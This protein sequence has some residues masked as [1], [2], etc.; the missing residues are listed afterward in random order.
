MTRLS[1]IAKSSEN[2]VVADSI[3]FTSITKGLDSVMYRLDITSNLCIPELGY[4]MAERVL[5]L[6]FLDTMQ[7]NIE[8]VNMRRS[9][10]LV[11]RVQ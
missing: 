8:I 1:Y 10:L 4:K 2:V 5:Y 6:L 11:R 7:F 9:R 3:Q